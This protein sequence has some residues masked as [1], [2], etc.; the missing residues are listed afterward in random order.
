MTKLKL[1]EV[2]AKLKKERIDISKRTFEYYQRLG[3]LPRPEKQ[4]GEKG[5]GVYGYYSPEIIGMVK[6]IIELKEKGL[7]LEEIR[8]MLSDDLLKRASAQWARWKDMDKYIGLED[9][10]P[11]GPYLNW[12]ADDKTVEAYVLSKITE[13]TE[14]L[15]MSAV[16]TIGEIDLLTEQLTDTEVKA[17]SKI[18]RLLRDKSSRR[19]LALCDYYIRLAE[20]HGT[21]KGKTKEEWK[22]RQAMEI[23]RIRRLQHV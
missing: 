1:T 15:L 17:V 3:L 13:H 20:I 22:E 21:Y 19:S 5:R 7:T 23:E 6:K 18:I 14:L 2:L 11:G 10:D 9:I 8:H 4:V 16:Y 12:W